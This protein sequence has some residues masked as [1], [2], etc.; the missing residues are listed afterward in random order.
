MNFIHGFEEKISIIGVKGEVAK[1]MRWAHYFLWIYSG[2]TKVVQ[3]NGWLS[4][5]RKTKLHN[6][7]V[8]S[9]HDDS[10][11]VIHISEKKRGR[12]EENLFKRDA[13]KGNRLPQK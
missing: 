6:F 7:C 11:D 12:G 13:R 2:Q 8:T 4:A 10:C 3:S 9:E 1:E 5:M